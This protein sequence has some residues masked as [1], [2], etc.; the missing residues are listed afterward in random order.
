MVLVG[1]HLDSWDV[2]QGAMDDGGGAFISEE[3]RA[4]ISAQA[5]SVWLNV[6]LDVLWNRV[7]HKGNRPLLKTS[8]PFATLMSYYDKRQTFYALADIEL[9]SN[10]LNSIDEMIL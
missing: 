6:D 3:N 7:R 5:I 8:D 10:A 9:R 1:G 4:A 2:G